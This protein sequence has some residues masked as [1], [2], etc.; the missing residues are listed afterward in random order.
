MDIEPV[1][2]RERPI[3]R[4]LPLH[5]QPQ[6]FESFTGYLLRLTE[7]NGLRSTCEIAALAGIASPLAWIHSADFPKPAFTTLAQIAGCTPARVLLM[8]FSALGS[9]FGCSLHATPLHR[10]LQGSLAD[11]LRYCPSCLAEQYTPY[12][13]LL[14]RFVAL[15]G[16]LKHS[17][18]LLDRCGHCGS[19]PPLL[20]RASRMARCEVCH[21][22]LRTCQAPALSSSERHVTS[23]QTYEL[24]SVLQPQERRSEEAQAVLLGRRFALRRQQKNLSI[25][26]VAQLIGKGEQ[27]VLDMEYVDTSRKATL[28]DYMR[29][30]MILG[31][32]LQQIFDTLHLPS[33]GI[34]STFTVK[35]LPEVQEETILQQLEE[36]TRQLSEEDVLLRPGQLCKRIGISVKGLKHYPRVKSWLNR[37]RKSYQFTI[38][39]NHQREDELLQRVEQATVQLQEWGQPVTQTRICAIVGMTYYWLRTYP[40]VKA[41]LL[42]LS[43]KHPENVERQK[44]LREERLLEPTR[45]AIQQ[46]ASCHEPLTQQT[47]SQAIGISREQFKEYSRLHALLQQHHKS[48]PDYKRKVQLREEELVTRVEEAIN[49]LTSSGESPTP[50]RICQMVGLPSIR[51]ERFWRVKKLLDQYQSGTPRRRKQRASNEEKGFLERIEQ[52]VEQLRKNGEPILPRSVAMIAHLPLQKIDDYPRVKARLQRILDQYYQ[53]TTATTITNQEIGT[54]R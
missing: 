19:M 51:L 47:V 4:L 27:V 11:G 44:R 25:T 2:D 41:R 29:Y 10:F 5:P 23:I 12:Y 32:S 22:D 46:L 14:W 50:R 17:K 38:Q 8:T 43:A 3:W 34:S 48:N 31:F 33:D 49:Q 45:Q 28:A 9:N 13:S 7:A 35:R 42:Q 16:C 18:V 53:H 24:A 36:A 26:Q 1:L 39:K 40:R 37:Y 21:G 54:V 20:S 30:T 15:P 52:A 6:P